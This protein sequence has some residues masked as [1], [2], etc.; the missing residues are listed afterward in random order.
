MCEQKQLFVMSEQLKAAE[1]EIQNLKSEN[2]PIIKLSQELFVLV[3]GLVNVVSQH[4]S[5]VS[6]QPIGS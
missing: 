3:N 5:S 6:C 4:V 1:Q 2:K